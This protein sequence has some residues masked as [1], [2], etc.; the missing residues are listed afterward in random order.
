MK[1][2]SFR[3]FYFSRVGL[4]I[5]MF[6]G[7]LTFVLI[8]DWIQGRGPINDLPMLAF[9][10]IAPPIVIALKW[11][12]RLLDDKS[13]LDHQKQLNDR[14]SEYLHER[15]RL[16][17]VLL[18]LTAVLAIW[19][20][21]AAQAKVIPNPAFAKIFAFVLMFVVVAG[22]LRFNVWADDISFNPDKS[23]AG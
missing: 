10:V 21:Y 9:S 22:L 11:C 19:L 1:S 14:P 13:K 5:H 8:R 6:F 23:D 20:V 4:L 2:I 12:L 7:C 15:K 16:R 17:G 18:G 3:R